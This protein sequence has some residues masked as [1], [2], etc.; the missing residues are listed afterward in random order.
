MPR[1]S[2]ISRPR[3]IQSV[4]VETVARLDRRHGWRLIGQIGELPALWNWTSYTTGSSRIRPSR[5][6][7]RYGASGRAGTV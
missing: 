1:S 4:E 5:W 6:D 2:G 3:V 7:S